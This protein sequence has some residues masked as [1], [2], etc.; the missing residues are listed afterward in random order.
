MPVLDPAFMQLKNDYKP[1]NFEEMRTKLESRPRGE[2]RYEI[3]LKQFVASG[4]QVVVYFYAHRPETTESWEGLT[5][6]T[7]KNGKLLEERSYLTSVK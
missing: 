1:L 5:M 2:R 6:F 3:I 4:N 7:L